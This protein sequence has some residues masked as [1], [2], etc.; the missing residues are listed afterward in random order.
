MTVRQEKTTVRLE[1]VTTF[2]ID[3]ITAFAV[4]LRGLWS[5]LRKTHRK[6]ALNRA[7]LTRNHGLKR[8]LSHILLMAGMQLKLLFLLGILKKRRHRQGIGC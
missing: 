2:A 6:N 5:N 7:E 1:R 3:T 4:F 8:S